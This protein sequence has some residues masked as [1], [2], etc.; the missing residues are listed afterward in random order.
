MEESLNNSI[1]I[2]AKKIRTN[3]LLYTEKYI[4]EKQNKEKNS[5]EILSLK[6]KN[7]FVMDSM[8]VNFEEFY[9]ERNVEIITQEVEKKEKKIIPNAPPMSFF[10]E[11][12]KLVCILK[13]SPM[14]STAESNPEEEVL[15]KK[16]KFLEKKSRTISKK[17]VLIDNNIN[18]IDNDYELK[19]Q[20]INNK[21]IKTFDDNN[22]FNC[23]KK[24]NNIIG[25]KYLKN[26]SKFLGVVPHKKHKIIKHC[27]VKKLKKK[28]LN[29]K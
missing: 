27:L 15:N 29:K 5:S 14:L 20:K 24:N 22:C 17:I 1:Y 21:N 9:I 2:K 6:N 4:K 23:C 8:A 7:N 26:L 16:K 13:N 25:K 19:N 28:K 3:L 11:S 18:G 10:H 12:K